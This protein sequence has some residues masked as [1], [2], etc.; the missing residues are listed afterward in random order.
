MRGGL[1]RDKK[2]AWL[3][4]HSYIHDFVHRICKNS[5][6]LFDCRSWSGQRTMWSWCAG[7]LMKVKGRTVSA[8]TI[9]AQFGLVQPHLSLSLVHIWLRMRGVMMVRHQPRGI[10]PAF[11]FQCCTWHINGQIW[12]HI[13]LGSWTCQWANKC[14]ESILRQDRRKIFECI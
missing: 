6:N 13:I 4:V 5:N 7:R 14:G 11:F 10:S 3:L 2:N 9:M 12:S 8:M 1:N